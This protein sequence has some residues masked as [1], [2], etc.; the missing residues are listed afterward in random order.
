MTSEAVVIDIRTDRRLLYSLSTCPHLTQANTLSRV[1]TGQFLHR[2]VLLESGRIMTRSTIPLQDLAQCISQQQD[3]LDKLRREYEARETQLR[4]LTRRKEALQTQ[5][6]QVEAELRGVGQGSAVPPEPAAAAPTMPAK[7]ATTKTGTKPTG[8]GTLGQLLVQIVAEAGRPMPI[9]ELAAEVVRRKYATTSR[10]IPALVADRVKDLV[11]K[12]FLRR[13]P[14]R[15]GVLPAQTKANS[16]APAPKSESGAPATKQK[17]PAVAGAAT[18]APLAASASAPSLPVVV[19]KILAGSPE[20]LTVG[21]LAEKVLASG[22]QT[23]SKDFT[24]VIRVVIGKMGNVENVPGKGYRLKKRKTAA[25]AS[26]GTG[27]GSK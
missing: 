20:P 3:E 22:Y 27:K 23:K 4:E 19:T 12:R 2:H 21:K 10:N 13:A 7:P 24:N 8:S 9:K 14:N 18:T 15:L 17:T 5:L 16:K 6:Q 26:N 1:K 11:K 25:A